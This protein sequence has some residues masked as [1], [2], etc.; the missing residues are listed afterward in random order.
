LAIN[1]ATVET[2]PGLLSRAHYA[3][4][5]ILAFLERNDEAMKEFDAVINLGRDIPG[6]AYDQAVEGKKRLMQPK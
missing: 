1:S 2:E 4:A 5:S 6:N 3:I